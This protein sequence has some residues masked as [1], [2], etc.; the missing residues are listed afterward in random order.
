MIG[1]EDVK[2]D[3]TFNDLDHQPIDRAPARGGRVQDVRAPACLVRRIPRYN[4]IPPWVYGQGQ[5]GTPIAETL[6][7]RR[8]AFLILTA[9]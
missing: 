2:S 3:M 4:N 1:I 7:C 6:E 5:F 8:T 9:E